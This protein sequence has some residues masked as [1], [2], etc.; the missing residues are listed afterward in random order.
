MIMGRSVD[1]NLIWRYSCSD[2]LFLWISIL[3]L[4]CK[5]SASH[6]VREPKIEIK[7]TYLIHTWSDTAFEGTVVN[8]ELPSLHGGLLDSSV[9]QRTLYSSV[10]QRTLYSSVPQIRP[11]SWGIC[12]MQTKMRQIQKTK[13]FY[14][15]I[16]FSEIC[17]YVVES[18]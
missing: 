5:K 14:R 9:Q 7:H 11:S 12:M 18:T 8:R 13:Y 3:F 1:K 15:L 4:K 6:F 10:Q 17:M 2:C 16:Y